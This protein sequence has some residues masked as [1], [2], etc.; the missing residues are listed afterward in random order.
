[1]YHTFRII[2][3]V[4]T[5]LL[6]RGDQTGGVQV[7]I[8]HRARMKTTVTRFSGMSR[9][10]GRSRR[11][12]GLQVIVL[13]RRLE[14]WI[15]HIPHIRLLRQIRIRILQIHLCR[16][17]LMCHTRRWWHGM[18]I[19]K[20]QPRVHVD[21]LPP[22]ILLSRPIPRQPTLILARNLARLI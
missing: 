9:V 7:I 5:S 2:E 15:I 17:R 19:I 16:K 12:R 8:P 18:G 3:I 21:I 13:H 14:K 10:C 4:L 20:S 1:M 11:W 22:Q 6:I